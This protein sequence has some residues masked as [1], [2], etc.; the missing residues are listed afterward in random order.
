MSF[1][2]SKLFWVV[3]DPANVLL[4][5]LCA[6]AVLLRTRW[7]ALGRRLVS[8]A[9]V[10]ALA[11]TALPVGSW[12]LVPLENRFPLLVRLP[13]RVDG[14]I[15]LGGA[16]DQLLT[17]ARGQPALKAEAERLTAFVALARRYPDAKLV[18]S[19]GSGRLTRQEVKET[20]AA[21][22]LFE[23]LG[24][25]PRRVLFEDQSRN[26]FENALY[27]RR[28]AQPAP[29]EAWLLVTSA[30]HMPRAVGCFRRLG[31]R[32]TPYPVDFRTDGR[33]GLVSSLSFTSGLHG[34]GEAVHEWIGLAAYRVMGR[35]DSL[36]PGPAQGPQSLTPSLPRARA[37]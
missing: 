19:G 1:V 17:V 30:L 33:F 26:T 34:F 24:L 29:G 32:V 31:W 6:G 18:Y 25:D 16:V 8:L 23:E 12:L 15:T 5:L 7:Q 10:A 14:I 2:L 27:S 21:R 9:A 20:V 36:W 4:A 11:V 22:Q 28:L 35:T 3:A 37:S 13:D